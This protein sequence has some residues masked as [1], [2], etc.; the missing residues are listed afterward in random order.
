[1]AVVCLINR[2]IQ[3]VYILLTHILLNLFYFIHFRIS[4][5]Y[6]R[7]HKHITPTNYTVKS[8]SLHYIK[9]NHINILVDNFNPLNPEL[10]PICHLLALLGAHH[11]LHVSRLR[12]NVNLIIQK[13]R[14]VF[15]VQLWNSLRMIRRYRNM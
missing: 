11:N 3:L 2:I 12:V 5:F 15:E 4:R 7:I 10:N 8:K 14:N 9:D 1:M 13:L 6:T